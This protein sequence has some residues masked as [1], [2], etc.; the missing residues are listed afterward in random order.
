MK[1]LEIGKTDSLKG[2]LLLL[3]RARILP[4]KVGHRSQ[5]FHPLRYVQNVAF[6]EN[7]QNI[8]LL[9]HIPPEPYTLSSIVG[10]YSSS[11]WNLVGIMNAMTNSTVVE[12]MSHGHTLKGWVRKGDTEPA[13]LSVSGYSSLKLSHCGKQS[14]G[15]PKM[16]MS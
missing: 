7:G 1:K 10:V 12:M 11:P 16:S 3:L 4:Q 6:C 8:F 14:H 5:C 9:P 13:R 15:S 2:T